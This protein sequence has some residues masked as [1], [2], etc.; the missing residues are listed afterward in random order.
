M[1][2]EI[3][4][5]SVTNIGKSHDLH[6]EK[7]RTVFFPFLSTGRNKSSVLAIQGQWVGLASQKAVMD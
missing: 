7:E 3:H 1:Y 2:F 5:N 4:F 6:N